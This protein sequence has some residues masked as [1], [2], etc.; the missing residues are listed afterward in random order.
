[1]TPTPDSFSAALEWIDRFQ[2]DEAETIR[3]A[4]ITAQKVPALVEAL[5]NVQHLISDCAY[6]GF[7]DKQKIMALYESNQITSAAIKQLEQT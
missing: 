7:V 1:M 2:D 6:D 5:K 4:L 3:E